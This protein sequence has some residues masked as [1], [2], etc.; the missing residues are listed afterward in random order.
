MTKGKLF[1]IS[2][3]SEKYDLHP[4]T[5]RHYEREGLITPVR[6]DGNTRLYDEETLQRIELIITLT[7]ELGVNLAGVE[8]ILNMREKMIRMQQEFKKVLE[9]AL[10]EIQTKRQG[11]Q[12]Y[13]IV[14][15]KRGTLLPRDHD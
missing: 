4:Q 10:R 12:T 13:T 11:G 14:P 7:R 6:S 2:Y 3:V 8:V 9:A 15:V 1:Y 5:L